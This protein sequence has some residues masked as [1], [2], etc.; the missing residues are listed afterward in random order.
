MRKFVV[1]ISVREAAVWMRIGGDRDIC[2]RAGSARRG[3]PVARCARLGHA[4]FFL[5]T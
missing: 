2:S 5:I 4:F 3:A 1:M